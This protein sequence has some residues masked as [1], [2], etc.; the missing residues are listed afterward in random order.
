MSSCS[1]SSCGL[2]CQ[3]QPSCGAKCKR[4]TMGTAAQQSVNN[5]A[6]WCKSWSSMQERE[7][8]SSVYAAQHTPQTHRLKRNVPTATSCSKLCHQHCMQCCRCNACTWP[9]LSSRTL[10]RTY[11][12]AFASSPW[13]LAVA[14]PGILDWQQQA[15]DPCSCTATEARLH[16]AVQAVTSCHYRV[17]ESE[18]SAG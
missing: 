5:H 2:S 13:V 14:V 3:Q 4:R 16:R 10:Q 15:P 11:L 8:R 17:L 12:A 18:D 9:A 6:L 7:L 1:C